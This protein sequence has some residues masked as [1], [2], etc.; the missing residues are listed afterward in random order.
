MEIDLKA[1][2]IKFS[3]I[4]IFL[5]SILAVI[6]KS[7]LQLF[8]VS[9]TLALF[10]TLYL[11]K[12]DSLSNMVTI[13][14]RDNQVLMIS[15]SLV[16]LLISLSLILFSVRSSLYMRPIAYFLLSAF[17]ISLILVN[18]LFIPNSHKYNVLTLLS[19]VFINFSLRLTPQLMY[20]DL[21]GIDPWI[22]REYTNYLINFGHIESGNNY[23]GM[24]AFHLI[25]GMTSIVTALPYKSAAIAS[26]TLLQVISFS[27]IYLMGRY[28][29]NS[30]IG[31]F[32]AVLLSTSPTLIS[33]GFWI[34][35]TTFGLIISIILIFLLIRDKSNQVTNVILR[36]ILAYS[37]IITHM[38]VG[39]SITIL[40]ATF[41]IGK[42][43]Y[44]HIYS[45]E[46]S[47]KTGTHFLLL[48][49]ILMFSW[50]M[51]ISGHFFQ[52][53]HLVDTALH[54]DVSPSNQII[55]VPHKFNLKEYVLKLVPF[56]AYF[57][58]S[59]IGFLYSISKKSNP[60]FFAITLCGFC[61][62]LVPLTL[63][64]TELGGLLG[65]RWLYISQIALSL[66]AGAGLFILISN[67][68]NK[69]KQ[70]L[71]FL[72]ILIIV[73]LNILNPSANTDN[74]V[75]FENTIS[76]SASSEGELNSVYFTSSYVNT[77]IYADLL[78]YK[79]LNTKFKMN[80]SR[81][82]PII[83]KEKLLETDGFFLI[84]KEGLDQKTEGLT[85]QLD[86]NL[87]LL[88]NKSSG[89]IQIYDN[90]AVCG[91]IH[92]RK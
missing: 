80:S 54:F 24:P 3:I 62:L 18:V 55:T 25:I 75:I 89:F 83:N 14:S 6:M 34:H 39:L 76:P 49:L 30:K 69:L 67:P 22:H 71:Y 31:F 4:G 41:L 56:L 51:Y 19:I 57:G 59:T 81:I 15:Y 9:F 45:I 43:I 68:S 38:Q 84:K 16:F 13:Y 1:L 10:C 88:D 79:P 29:L 52:F 36:L 46:I 28:I 64:Q 63:S 32:G 92:A 12:H 42:F 17:S 5:F 78:L 11:Y 61:I 50:W 85:G 44:S 47:E 60:K 82:E 40:L 33:L 90:S 26:I 20:P 7:N 23:S 65:E 21:V 87:M 73:L 35:P 2:D 86:S 72:F 91:Y 48:Y 58:L 70:T 27:L 8:L 53:F 37:I 74:P 66:A 77:S